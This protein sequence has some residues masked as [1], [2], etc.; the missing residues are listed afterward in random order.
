MTAIAICRRSI[1]AVY[2]AFPGTIL[3]EDSISELS[4]QSNFQAEYGRNS[5]AVVNIVTKSGTN[6]LHGAAFEDFRNAVLNARNFFN[7]KDQPK[8]AFRNNQ[9]GGAIGGPIVKDKAFFY[10]F[11]RRPARRDGDHFNQ[12]G[13]H[14]Q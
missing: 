4:I 6:E 9:F 2:S 13:S 3:P 14:A 8:D 10:L 7:T 12:Y 1:R 11:L 5:G